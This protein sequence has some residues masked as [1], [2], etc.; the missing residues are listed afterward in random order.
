[1]TIDPV[2]R[3]LWG[4]TS[5]AKPKFLTK[6]HYDHLQQ[7]DMQ[8]YNLR[9]LR[10]MMMLA[11][12]NPSIDRRFGLWSDEPEGQQ[13]LIDLLYVMQSPQVFGSTVRAPSGRVVNTNI[14]WGK[15]L[16]RVK[17]AVRQQVPAGTFS[18]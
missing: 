4:D 8:D 2:Y 11:Q 12:S 17:Q 10:T 18:I 5:I 6:W 9:P 13:D 7:F 14:H 3:L 16:V 1:M 15:R